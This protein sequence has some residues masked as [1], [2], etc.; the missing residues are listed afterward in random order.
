MAFQ[1]FRV[2]KKPTFRFICNRVV[3]NSLPFGKLPVQLPVRRLYGSMIHT[4]EER[5]PAVCEWIDRETKAHCFRLSESNKRALFQDAASAAS[6][7]LPRSRAFLDRL[8]KLSPEL[9]S[10]FGLRETAVSEAPLRLIVPPFSKLVEDPYYQV[11]S[12]IVLSYCWHNEEWKPVP[13]CEKGWWPISD[14]MMNLLQKNCGE[15]E[16]IW[17][18]QLWYWNFPIRLND[19]F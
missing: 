7:R 6:Q 14:R 13:G 11:E 8:Q 12:F 16:G 19:M 1:P 3:D 2:F 18:D 9:G 10:Q 5:E 4:T 15:N 17:I